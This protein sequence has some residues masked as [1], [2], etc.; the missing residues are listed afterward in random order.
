V[1]FSH[2][3]PLLQGAQAIAMVP[4]DGVPLAMPDDPIGSTFQ[5]GVT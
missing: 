3:T 5:V 1:T 2:V 4:P